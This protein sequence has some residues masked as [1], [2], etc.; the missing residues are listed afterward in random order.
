MRDCVDPS[1]LMNGSSGT[2]T[3]RQFTPLRTLLHVAPSVP[4]GPIS[5]AHACPFRSVN[6]TFA[7]AAVAMA[8]E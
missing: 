8:C 5:A 3:S 6:G 2:A 4:G 7:R 1:L